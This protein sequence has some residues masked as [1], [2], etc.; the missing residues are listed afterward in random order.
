MSK[1][2][3][4]M[5]ENSQSDFNATSNSKKSRFKRRPKPTSV[6]SEDA[7][8][9]ILPPRLAIYVVGV[10]LNA[11][12]VVLNTRCDLGTSTVNCIPLVFSEATGITLGQGCMILYAIDVVIQIIVFRKLTAVMALQIPF[13]F[14]FGMLVDAYDHL[15]SSGIWW[16]FQDPSIPMGTFMLFFGIL[17]TGTGVSMMMSMNFIPNPPDGC[18]LAVCKITG[19]PFGRGKWLNDG[20]RLLLACGLSLALIGQIIGV[21]L[22]TIACVF[23]IGNTCQFV[24]DHVG[25][26]YRKVYNPMG[27]VDER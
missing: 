5:D 19:L 9:N 6:T 17:L 15:I 16:F 8:V 14:V 25:H 18:T 13:S 24:D 22:G 10:L 12:G 26:L 27:I 3:V 4:Q 20:I 11:L 23:L 2:S 21:G 7:K 1:K